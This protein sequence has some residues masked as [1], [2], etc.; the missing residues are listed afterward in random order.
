M[1]KT[2]EAPWLAKENGMTRLVFEDDFDSLDT[3][4][5]ENTGKEGYKWYTC[6]AFGAQPMKPTDVKIEDS[7]LTLA[8][9]NSIWNYAL[10]TF[11]PKTNV[12]WAFCQGVLEF[13]IRIP[14][15]R[16]NDKE[17]GEKG[18][19]AVWSF[20]PDKITDETVEW[21]EPDWMEYWGDGYY[22][23]TFHHE[24][25]EY[26]RGPQIYSAT[27]WNGHR[28]PVA[29]TDGE[30]HTM[31]FLW[32]EGSIESWL[33]G[34]PAVKQTYRDG[35]E[36][37]PKVSVNEGEYDP[38][39]YKQLNTVPQALI[40]GGSWCNPLEIDWIRVWQK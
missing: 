17:A 4:D 29:F 12:G 20:P 30:W 2:I 14:R 8:C 1:S 26:V 16:A 25:R 21:V 18:V 3:I 40:L 36:P 39:V 22:T 34:V 32:Q 37:E 28:G 19:P 33:D 15:P 11:N 13:R 27:N 38:D 23:T 24:K 35:E 9:E 5:L 7:V 10:Q 31:T 6:R